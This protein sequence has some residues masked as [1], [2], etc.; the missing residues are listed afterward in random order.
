MRS[1]M[2]LY[3]LFVGTAVQ[4]VAGFVTMG[5]GETNVTG[6]ELLSKLFQAVKLLSTNQ[7]VLLVLPTTF[8]CQNHLLTEK[9]D[10][11]ATWSCSDAINLSDRVDDSPAII[12]ALLCDMNTNV[13]APFKSWEEFSP[14]CCIFCRSGSLLTLR[15]EPL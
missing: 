1:T 2:L 5:N 14:N 11:I 9:V 13:I 4:I 3:C 12:I 10:V 7:Q 15:T 8:R 6:C